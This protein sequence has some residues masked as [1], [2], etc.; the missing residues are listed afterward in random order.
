MLKRAAFLVGMFVMAL[1]ATGCA[2]TVTCGV[3]VNAF[4]A[5]NASA[6]RTYVVL[7]LDR[8]VQESDLQ[9]QEFSRYVRRI[10]NARG[11]KQARSFEDAQIAVFVGYGIGNPQQHLSTYNVPVWGQTGVAASTT[12]SQVNM[13]GNAAT[14]TSDTTY[15]PQFGVT[16][17][18]T[19]TES[20]TTYRRYAVV[21]AVDVA[22]YKAEQRSVEVWTTTIVSEGFSPDLRAIFPLMIVGAYDLIGAN[23][24]GLATRDVEIDGKM[25]QWMTRRGAYAPGVAPPVATSP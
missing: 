24:G 20:F 12:T 16:G 18:R 5:P 13:Y 9:F 15:T 4:A 3:S 17:Y 6:Y 7:P 1:A 22:R 10:L 14:V 2:P 19:E 8:N 25:A 21:N 23:S 11:F